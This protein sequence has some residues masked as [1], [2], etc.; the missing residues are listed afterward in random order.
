MR[1][2]KKWKLSPRYVGLYKI[3]KRVCK[4]SNELEYPAELATMYPVFHIPLLKKFVG[5][6]AL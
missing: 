3:L 5:G 1:F 6:L 2:G 4:V